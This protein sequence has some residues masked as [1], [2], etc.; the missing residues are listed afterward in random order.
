MRSSRA[1]VAFLFSIAFPI[2]TCVGLYTWWATRTLRGAGAGQTTD[3]ASTSGGTLVS[4]RRAVGL[5]TFTARSDL[6]SS[7]RER[8]FRR[9]LLLGLALGFAYF[10]WPT[11]WR[12]DRIRSAQGY[13]AP[14]RVNRFTGTT[15]L[16]S[17]AGWQERPRGR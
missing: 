8:R 4:T 15:Q 5:T 9:V 12:Y 3:L 17:P 13:E 6:G 1:A 16:L 2:G 11:P 7:V 10:V 14:I